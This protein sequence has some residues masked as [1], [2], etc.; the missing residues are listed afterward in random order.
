MEVSI[1]LP[2]F[3]NINTL[4]YTLESIIKQ[5][6]KNFELIIIDDN[7]T[8]GSSEIAEKFALKYNNCFYKKIY[9][10]YEKKFYNKI[11]VDVGT[12]ACNEALK[13]TKGKWI[14]NTGDEILISNTIEIMLQLANRSDCDHLIVDPISISENLFSELLYKKFNL[15]KYED[16]NK[17]KIYDAQYLF[18]IAKNQMGII[19]K[20]FP[21]FSSRFS[22][23]FKNNI[24]LSRLFY[25]GFKP[26]PGCAGATLIKRK[27][28]DKIKWRYL[29]DRVW[30]SFNGRG[31]DRDLNFRI[32]YEKKRSKYINIPLI[33][34]NMDHENDKRI[35]ENYLY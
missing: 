28:L 21:G 8:D 12:T 7:S 13:Y 1:I 20:I 31:M 15:E 34:S 9:T 35:I 17:I 6:F 27:I 29:S 32:I 10:D 26:L 22:F 33:A 25:G 30:P 19:E 14:F 23:N 4:E 18:Q 11:N 5:T 2:I 3:N 16:E 24:L